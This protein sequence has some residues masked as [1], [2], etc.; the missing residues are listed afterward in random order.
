MASFLKKTYKKGKKGKGTGTSGGLSVTSMATKEIVPGATEITD[1]YL[2]DDEIK[3][4]ITKEEFTAVFEYDINDWKKWREM[5][6]YQGFNPKRIIKLM[7]MSAKV[8]KAGSNMETASITLKVDGKDV[9]IDLNSHQD[10]MKDVQM[11]IELFGTRGATWKKL[12]EKSV[13]EVASFLNWME[14][15]YNI[16]TNVHLSG[17]S[18]PSDTIT[19][20]RIISCFPSVVC[21]MYHKNIGKK[22]MKGTDI[23]LK[24]TDKISNSVF[25]PFMT[26]LISI[27]QSKLGLAP[28]H[29]FFMVHVMVD[30]VIHKKTKAYTDLETMLAYYIAAFRSEATPEL[31]RTKFTETVEVTVKGAFSQMIVDANRICKDLIYQARPQ[32]PNVAQVVDELTNLKD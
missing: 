24:E 20:P 30:N 17:T 5:M 8:H 18:L 28:H 29:F 11:M 10:V 26:S 15:K 19:I 7:I 6:L 13:P 2:Q 27:E 21:M 31:S 12:R 14:A 3:A 1:Y 25:T 9:K 4:N 22:V 32:D 16:D 23:G